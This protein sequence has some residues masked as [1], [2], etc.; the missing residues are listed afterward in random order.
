MYILHYSCVVILLHVPVLY[1]AVSPYGK[2][3][4]FTRD[5]S[6]ST[7]YS[8]PCQGSRHMYLAHVL[9][10]EYTAGNYTM[11]IPP[12]KN[13]RNDPN[14]L[15]DSVVDDIHNPHV[16][17]VFFADQAHPEYLITYSS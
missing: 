12:P 17:V 6:S 16:F 1:T 5:A 7:V 3:M 8:V 2:G 13:L 11:G 9:T 10:G 4:Y 15:F 14:V